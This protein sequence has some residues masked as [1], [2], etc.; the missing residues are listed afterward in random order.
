[1]IIEFQ[2]TPTGQKHIPRPQLGTPP[3][4]HTYTSAA[5]MPPCTVYAG[6]TPHA[7]GNSYILSVKII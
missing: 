3:F 4:G 5:G 2:H 6:I 1:M 7:I